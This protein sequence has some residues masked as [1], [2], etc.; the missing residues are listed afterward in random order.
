MILPVCLHVV[1]RIDGRIELV[2]A[3]RLPRVC[4]DRPLHQRGSAGTRTVSW[5]RP[6]GR[7][8][9]RSG[10]SGRKSERSDIAR[11]PSERLTP[12]A[13]GRAGKT[14]SQSS[15]PPLGQQF[16][17][18]R[19]AATRR[20]WPKQEATEQRGTVAVPTRTWRAPTGSGTPGRGR[21]PRG[22][23]E[24]PLLPGG[25]DRGDHHQRQNGGRD[26]PADHRRGD[27]LHDLLPSRFPTDQL[28]PSA[29]LNTTP[30][31]SAK[32]ARA[33]SA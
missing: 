18:D 25:V 21:V 17:P 28:S 6:R 16:Q 11:A 12:E 14:S 24:R 19:S 31:T 32:V 23:H 27:Q 22:A 7:E 8:D 10:S 5:I 29:H 30:P 4:R 9:A 13:S 3:A 15:R 26:H 2:D 20:L 33:S 1:A